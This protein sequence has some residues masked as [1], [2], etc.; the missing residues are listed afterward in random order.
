MSFDPASVMTGVRKEAARRL[1][2]AAIT[3][4]THHRRDLSRGNPAPHG[5]PALKGEFP[6]LRTGGLRAGVA[7]EPAS[8]A[9]VMATGRVVVGYRPAALHGLYLGGQG[10]RW[11]LDTYQ[12]ERGAIG[13]ILTGGGA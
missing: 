7:V 11:V 13:R 6:R 4:Q 3:L 10:W 2:A 9:A 1:L 8:L 12:R 5:N